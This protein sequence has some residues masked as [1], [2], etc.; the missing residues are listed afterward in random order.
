MCEQRLIPA[1]ACQPGTIQ[2]LLPPEISSSPQGSVCNTFTPISHHNLGKWLDSLP[3]QVL[4]FSLSCCDALSASTVAFSHSPLR[5]DL[6][7]LPRRV[8]ASRRFLCSS[9]LPGLC[10]CSDTLM[11]LPL[12]L[13]S[14]IMRKFPL[15]AIPKLLSH[16]FGGSQNYV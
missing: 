12:V 1:K 13:R 6:C 14:S 4:P 10:S 5:S 15:R 3:P 7:L 8:W 2:W 11:T 16:E 9:P